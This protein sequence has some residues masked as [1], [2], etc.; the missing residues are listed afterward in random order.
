MP[1]PKIR[2]STLLYGVGAAALA[3]VIVWRVR[4]PF[5]SVFSLGSGG[6]PG[7]TASQGTPGLPSGPLPAGTTGLTNYL[8]DAFFR[9]VEA[10]A[11]H[12]RSRGATITGEDL[13]AIFL[14]ESGVGPHVGNSIGC[15]GLNQI[16]NL[17]SVGWTGTGAEYLSLPGEQQI[18]FVQRYF[19]NVNRYPAI[20]DFGSLYL[21]NFN[22]GHMGKPDS[23]VLYRAG[24]SAY[25]DNRGV[26][27]GNKGF[28]EIADM[29]KFVAQAVNRN[30][31]KWN[32]LRM[33]LQRANAGVA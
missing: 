20:R 11:A 2:T 7:K 8:S 24:D 15:M 16:C 25:A 30:P 19:D 1:A 22:P 12:M 3:S 4:N 9:A 21:A 10:L 5:A 6:A 18:A 14:A 33:R 17:K 23:F 13:L 26:D 27:F 31:A 32:E 29:A 28:I